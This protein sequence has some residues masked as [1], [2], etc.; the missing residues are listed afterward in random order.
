MATATGIA[1]I[2]ILAFSSLGLAQRAGIIAAVCLLLWLTQWVPVWVPTVVLWLSTPALLWQFDQRFAPLAVIQWSI[3]PVLALFLGGFALAAAAR[4]HGV[5]A[6]VASVALRVAGRSPTRLL[7]AAAGATALLSMWMSNV[8]AAALMLNAFRPI[9]D[10]EPSGSALRR[11]LLLV[12]ALSADVGGIATPIGTGAN[13]IAMAAVAHVRQISFLHWMAFGVPLAMGLVIASVALVIIRLRPS[14][15]GE[16]S[17]LSLAGAGGSFADSPPGAQIGAATASA[18]DAK[19]TKKSRY[20]L[21]GIFALTVLLW[22]SEPWHGAAAWL[23][24]LGAV[25]AMVV[26]RVLPVREIRNLDWGTL[27]LVAG[28]I[29]MGALLDRSG[30]VH[31]MAG[32]LPMQELPEFL[33][34]FTL[35]VVSATLSALMSNTGTAALLI[36]LAA[37]I[38]PSPSTA[39]IVAVAASLGVPFVVSTPPNAMAV[40]GG[41]KSTDLLVPGLILMLGG[42]L[43]IAATGHW[44]LRA[45]GIP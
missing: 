20:L 9:W 40:A 7:A 41:L 16:H 36:P 19:Q 42:C 22:L 5:D 24:A 45:V 29:G 8:A 21:G 33:R 27:L 28:G 2:A 43:L 4:C 37:T 18:I 30:I 11:S 26:L 10:R 23:V 32:R 38:D 6:S 25:G 12:I 34:I 3:D 15:P 17:E 14:L 1:V 39:I 44:V 31:A 13:G 35:C